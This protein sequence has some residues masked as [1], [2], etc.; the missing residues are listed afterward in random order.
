MKPILLSIIAAFLVIG[1]SKSE[2]NA[3][4]PAAAQGEATLE[5][6][7]E[8]VY[9]IGANGRTVNA[10]KQRFKEMAASSENSFMILEFKGDTLNMYLLDSQPGEEIISTDFTSSF[11]YEDQ[12]IKTIDSK[13][14]STTDFRVV[15]LNNSQMTLEFLGE[16]DPLQIVFKRVSLQQVQQTFKYLLG[17]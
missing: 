2:S 8:Q 9:L 10:G 14:K 13:N 17:E 4:S 11:L 15:D 5:G 12:I 16:G 6:L 1:C 3:T 7:W